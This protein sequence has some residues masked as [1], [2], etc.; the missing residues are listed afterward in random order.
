MA[1]NPSPEVKIARD[2][3]TAIGDLK[4]RET[5]MCIVTWIGTDMTAGYASYGRTPGLCGMARRFADASYE[6]ISD[7]DRFDGICNSLLRANRTASDGTGIDFDA[8]EAEVIGK[9]RLL[10][11]VVQAE[12]DP[13]LRTAIVRDLV[14]PAAEL[15]ARF[16]ACVN[17]ENEATP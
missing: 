14:M 9:L 13:S 1:W 6:I 8:L 2:A 15:L 3:A 17:I 5:D 4:G 11:A 7:P 10:K 12:A 16:A